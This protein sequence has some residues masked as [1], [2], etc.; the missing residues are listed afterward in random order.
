[1]GLFRKFRRRF[2]SLIRH[3][4]KTLEKGIKQVVKSP[5]GLVAGSMFLPGVGPIVGKLTKPLLKPVTTGITSIFGHR[6]RGGESDVIEQLG[7]AQAEGDREIEYK[8]EGGRY[9][10]K[11]VEQGGN[12]FLQGLHNAFQQQLQQQ[13]AQQQQ[14]QQ[15]QGVNPLLFALD[16]AIKER[17][18]QDRFSGTSSGQFDITNILGGAT[19]GDIKEVIGEEYSKAAKL[20]QELARLEL[21]KIR[22]QQLGEKELLQSIAEQEMK[23]IQGKSGLLNKIG[24]LLDKLGAIRNVPSFLERPETINA[25]TGLVGSLMASKGAFGAFEQKMPPELQRMLQQSTQPT[26]EQR[27]A[28]QKLQELS[29]KI[30]QLPI[31]EAPQIVEPTRE[32]KTLEDINR[33]IEEFRNL[34]LPEKTEPQKEFESR[35]QQIAR[36]YL[37]GKIPKDLEQAL[38]AKR[39]ETVEKIGSLS[40]AAQER[41]KQMLA[42]RG[43]SAT[44]G[45]AIKGLEDIAQRGLEEQA[46]TEREIQQRI[47]E[48]QLLGRRRGEELASR[49]IEREEERGRMLSALRRGDLENV[50]RLLSQ[51]FA[52]EQGL[53]EQQQQALQRKFENDIQR[54]IMRKGLAQTAADIQQSILG[55]QAGMTEQQLRAAQLAAEYQRALAQGNAER[56][57]SIIQLLQSL[58]SK[59][60]STPQVSPIETA[61]AG[62]INQFGF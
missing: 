43:L 47:L 25:L 48:E 13:Q 9:V 22:E 35:M 55:Q 11:P 40:K 53:T 62:I 44:G 20:A 52:L 46:Q 19:G 14:A 21:Q 60:P 2:Q 28:L 36:D 6:K 12:W 30:E 27:L 41:L 58:F 24:N 59:I 17:F 49:I 15:Q 16:T 3:P 56:A 18:P 32:R 34:G 29:G 8:F 31:P 1:M 5:V 38:S 61:L 37:E 10:P 4:G 7:E 26:P 57:A 50:A 42:Q 51:R 23:K 54:S 33:T 45:V 39:S